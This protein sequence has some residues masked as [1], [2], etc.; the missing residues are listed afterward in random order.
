MTR[1]PWHHHLIS[2]LCLIV[3]GWF[4]VQL[5]AFAAT[6]RP[7][8]G[9]EICILRLKR[10]AKYYWEYRAQIS[11]DGNQQPPTRYNCRD[12]TQTPKG[13][14]TTSFTAES[15]GAFVCHLMQR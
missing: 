7:W 6:C 9:H 2:F 10:S 5:P 13:Q 12:R 11:I 3:L 8:Q 1:N 15:A 4:G 14:P